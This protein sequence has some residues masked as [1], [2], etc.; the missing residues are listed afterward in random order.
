M[1]QK[2]IKIVTYKQLNFNTILVLG[3]FRNQHY[4]IG[5]FGLVYVVQGIIFLDDSATSIFV[6]RV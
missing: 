5:T 1:L 6:P 4:L 2:D 3:D